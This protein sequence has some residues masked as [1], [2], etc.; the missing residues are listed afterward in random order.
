MVEI[1]LKLLQHIPPL[2]RFRRFTLPLWVR[3]ELGQ[4][5]VERGLVRHKRRHGRHQLGINLVSVIAFPG[6]GNA[7]THRK[8]LRRRQHTLLQARIKEVNV[9]AQ[10]LIDRLDF[11]ELALQRAPVR[12]KHLARREGQNLTNEREHPCAEAEYPILPALHV[13]APAVALPLRC[14]VLKPH[15]G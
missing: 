12:L 6:P 9:V 3:H 10:E 11:G 14:L 4:R 8:Q 13:I 7:Y 5:S 1:D 2:R 15:G